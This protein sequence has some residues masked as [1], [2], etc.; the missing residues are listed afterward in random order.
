MNWLKLDLRGQT[1]DARN[2]KEFFATMPPLKFGIWQ[3]VNTC[4]VTL[5]QILIIFA[6]SVKFCLS[7]MD[8]FLQKVNKCKPTFFCTFIKK[9]YKIMLVKVCKSYRLSISIVFH[10]FSQ[11]SLNIKVSQIHD[12]DRFWKSPS[13]W[14]KLLLYLGDYNI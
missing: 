8:S 9:T 1:N 13:H 2:N 14:E 3:M 5:H 10:K 6:I 12:I 7:H 4:L 11:F